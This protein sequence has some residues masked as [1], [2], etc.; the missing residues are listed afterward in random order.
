LNL[1]FNLTGKRRRKIMQRKVIFLTFIIA[2][3]TLFY[4]T[5]VRSDIPAPPVNQQLGVNDG[6]FNNIDE[7]DCRVCH[8][9]PDIVSGGSNIPDRH[10]LL[11]NSAIQTGECSATSNTCLADND[12]NSGICSNNNVP[13]SEDSDCPDFSLGETCGEICI[14]ETVVPYIDS[15]NDGINDTLYD[16]LNCHA[17]VWDPV[18]MSFV[19]EAFRDCTLCHIQIPGEGSVH[20][21]LP[22]AQG[23][24]SPLGDPDVGDCT[25][26]H[27][28]LVDDI[29]DGHQIPTY[30]PSLVTP[31]PSGGDGEPLNSRS[32]GAG[33]CNY[34]H[35]SGTDTI[36]GI[37]VFTNAETHH[38]TGV[39]QSETGVI[40]DTVCQWCHNMSLPEEYVIRPCE[41]CHGFEALHNIQLDSNSDDVIDPGSEMVGYGHIGNND[42]CWG[43]H[44]FLQAIA[45][46]TGPVVPFIGSSDV[47]SMATGTDTAVTLTGAALTNV[48]GGFQLKSDVTMTAADGSSVTLTPDSIS[49]GLLTVTVPGM[50]APGNY[51][52]RAVKGPA[53]SNPVVISV[54]PAVVIT[55]SS[56]NRKKGVLTING[57]G[58]SE[59][60]EGTDDYINVE[61]DGQTVDIVSWS[62]TQIKASV[63]SCTKRAII[64]V[65]ALF[66]SATNDSGGGG[67]KC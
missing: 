24:D 54:T 33:A 2:I 36:T 29:G 20:H 8:E 11:V 64:T 27:G 42:D 1:C 41:G 9:D 6:V 58:F 62:D 59:K 19:L 61:V 15:N 18:S 56:C 26:C 46:G 14:G 52:I 55:D 35:D 45:P 49:Q 12:C 32:N 38:N 16:C 31:S 28:T 44:G 51:A 50:T 53:E 57:S 13:C 47:M 4:V 21:L 39:F 63:S 34:C 10:H 22:V 48:I 37:E 5:T 65:N 67:G 60:P 66:G 30:Q 17:L 23:G 40:D 3:C 7:T 25:P 43:C